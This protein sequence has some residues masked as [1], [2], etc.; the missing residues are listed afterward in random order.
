VRRRY[1]LSLAVGAAVTLL[2]G[3]AAAASPALA[4]HPRHAAGV[5]APYFETWTKDSIAT[6]AHQS[7]ARFLTLAFI[8]A[9]GKKGAAACTVTWDGS[10]KQPISA[11]KYRAQIARLRR[12]GG[13]VIPSFGGFSA[14]QGG[15]E[16]ADSC[17]SVA[18]IATAYE[19]VVRT[20]R[21]SRLD[22]DVEARSL[23][24]KAGIARR[25]EAIAIAQRWAARRGIRLRIQFTIGIE[26]TGLDR[27]NLGVVRSAVA[28]GVRVSSVNLMV[29]DYY[30]AKEPK[31]L[32]MGRLAI[33]A[34]R[35]AHRQLM[36][37]FHGLRPARVWHLEGMT[38]LPGIDDYPKKTEVTYL[39]DAAMMLHFARAHRM[40][41]LSIWAIQRDH[42][43]CPGVID[44]NSCSGIKQKVWAFSHLLEPFTR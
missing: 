13:D 3:G 1:R 6:I 12:D 38:M 29:F 15:T 16:I 32:H 42:G 30:L 20:Y 2:T 17:H 36:A 25:S 33:E 24:N 27:F 41:F 11:G 28:H 23:T 22:M 43:G 44:S 26:P 7:G 4:A 19:Q 14:D 21:V 31:P 34:V 5:Y 35:N 8:Q 39:H 40:S 10:R 9:A 18:R 37:V